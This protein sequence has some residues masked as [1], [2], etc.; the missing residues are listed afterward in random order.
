MGLH[1]VCELLTIGVC[2]I[3][4][5][6]E[7]MKLVNKSNATEGLGGLGEKRCLTGDHER[8]ISWFY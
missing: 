1:S 8:G 2:M 3:L 6:T 5:A 4:H 7:V